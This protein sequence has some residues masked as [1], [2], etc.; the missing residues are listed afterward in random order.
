MSRELDQAKSE[1]VI[2]NRENMDLKKS[3]MDLQAKVDK[4]ESELELKSDFDVS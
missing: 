2:C 4:L 3:N 1:V